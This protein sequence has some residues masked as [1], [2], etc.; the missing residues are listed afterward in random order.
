MHNVERGAEGAT[1][2]Q[3]ILVIEDDRDIARLIEREL[4]GHHYR[5][6]RFENAQ[7]SLRRACRPDI[8]LIVL[9]LLL[10]DMHGFEVCQ[11]LRSEESTRAVPIVVVTALGDEAC[12]VRGFEVGADDYVTKPFSVRE[13]VTRVRA[14]LRRAAMGRRPAQETRGDVSIDRRR[15]EV[16][17]R[18][19]AVTL[20]PTEFSLLDFFAKHPDRVF[21]RD[22]LLTHLWGEESVILEHNLDVHICSLR[23]KIERDPK[24]PSLLVT[25]RNVGFKLV[26]AGGAGL[27]SP[28]A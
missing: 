25:I 17:V 11:R 18:G 14:L 6:E 5:V 4:V 28:V 19:E 13:L 20:T 12:R 8:D 10:P 15:H 26:D 24:Q 21:S 7:D 1:D 23:R 16:T 27:A 9:D 22:E 2:N 3:T